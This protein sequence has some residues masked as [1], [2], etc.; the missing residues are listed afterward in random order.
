MKTLFSDESEGQLNGHDFTAVTVVEFSPRKL[1]GFREQFAHEACKLERLIQGKDE[2]FVPKVPILHGTD[3][4]REY[5]DPQKF[6]YLKVFLDSLVENCS[7]IFRLGYFNK[8]I[9]LFCESKGQKALT[10]QRR[11]QFCLMNFWLMYRPPEDEPFTLIHELDAEATL[12]SSQFSNLDQGSGYS[13]LHEIGQES[14]I[15]DLDNFL[16]HYFAPKSEIG[17]QAADVCSYLA[18]KSADAR[19]TS[20]GRR[21]SEHFALIEN[22]FVYNRIHEMKLHGNSRL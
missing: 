19:A 21:M 22:K 12:R 10:R 3:F 9:Q 4:L 11:V 7:R 18:L 20:F 5:P 6:S 8:S 1:I 17:C 16:G 14:L 13:M 15:V 2:S